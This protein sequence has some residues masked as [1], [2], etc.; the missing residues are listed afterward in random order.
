MPRRRNTTTDGSRFVSVGSSR[1]RPPRTR[2]RHGQSTRRCRTN[3]SAIISSCEVGLWRRHR[4]CCLAVWLPRCP[5]TNGFRDTRITIC[6]CGSKRAGVVFCS[7]IGRWWSYIGR[8]FT[9]PRV[10][11]RRRVRLHFSSNT[12]GFSAAAP[13]RASLFS[14]SSQGACGRGG[15]AR[16]WASSGGIA[17]SV[18]CSWSIG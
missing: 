5:S 1:R 12:G 2:A 11:S 7:W 10:G 17:I 6:C 4:F 18:S 16:R 8:I 9:P 3:P 15:S 14:K 13:V